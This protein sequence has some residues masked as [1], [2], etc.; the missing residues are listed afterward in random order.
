MLLA[1]TC[2]FLLLS[3]LLFAC[4]TQAK[5]VTLTY[6]VDSYVSVYYYT[7]F[8]RWLGSTNGTGIVD[9]VWFEAGSQDELLFEIQ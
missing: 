8:S 3:L 1:R 6:S 7:G 5:N 4:S 9:S 2:L